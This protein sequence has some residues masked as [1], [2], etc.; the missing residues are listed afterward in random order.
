MV[1]LHDVGAAMTAAV[2]FLAGC[3]TGPVLSV[4]PSTGGSGNANGQAA[5]SVTISP[6]SLV[7][8]HGANWT[9]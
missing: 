4:M 1:R 5:V 6:Q 2:I 7:I 3:G 8:K 9:F